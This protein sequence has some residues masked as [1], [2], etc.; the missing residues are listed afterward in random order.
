MKAV[1]YVRVSTTEQAMHG[2]SLEAQRELIEQYAKNNGHNLVKIYADEGISASKALNKR[3]GI[4]QL[5][6]DAEKGNFDLILF[7]DLT[8]WSRSP[9][10]FYAV[11]DRLDKVSVS[12]IAVGQPNLETVTASGKLI[13]GIHISVAAHESAQTGERIKF[14]LKSKAENGYSV[15]S[16]MCLPVG[17]KNEEVN[18]NKHIVIDEN[19]RE[20][21]SS[22]FDI[23]E[24]THSIE[25]LVSYA[26]ENGISL[27]HESIKRMLSNTLYKGEYRG[28]QNYCEPYLTS[29]KWELLNR[30]SKQNPY[31]APTGKCYLFSS[32][33]RCKICGRVMVGHTNNGIAY[34]ECHGR[35]HDKYFA[36]REDNVEKYL[37]DIMDEYLSGKRFT[38]KVPQKQKNTAQVKGKLERLKELY[39]DGDIKK[40]DYLKRKSEL[41][42][43]LV[44]TPQE[45]KFIRIDG[46]KDYYI[47]ASK[48]AKKVAWHSVI[49]EIIVDK[50]KNLEAEF[51][52][53]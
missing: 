27:A 45:P 13:V 7:K 47:N 32:L 1:G 34:Y 26:K 52:T 10:Q 42:A 40:E 41:E 53:I 30:I 11:Q 16:R 35:N 20:F 19:K 36:V 5:L 33:V 44:E 18:G 17:Y 8:R 37:L 14:V 39:I 31:H 38:A 29:E 51:I 28:I 6:A 49:N 24:R 48:E 2:Y 3:K 9:S 15:L 25:S 4:L 21:V 43:Q 50:D 23:Y 46:W 22:L 12:W